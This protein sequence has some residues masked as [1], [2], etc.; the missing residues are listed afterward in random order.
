[1]KVKP[2]L[3]TGILV[4]LGYLAVVFTVWLGTGVDYDTIGDSVDNVR[5]AVT[6]AM[7]CGALY[8]LVVVSILGWWTPSLREPK[9]AHHGWMLAIPVLL[10]IG[11]VLNLAATEWGRFDELG[12]PLGT[13]VAWLAL[14]CVGVGFNEEMITR[15]QLIVGGR[16]SLHEGGV[17]FVSSLCF[18]LLH[19]PNAFFGQSAA[20]TVQQVVFAFAIG[21]A[22]YVTRRVTGLLLVPML[23]HGAWDFST[24][25]QGHSTDGMADKT[26]SFGS[27][28][29]Y[30]AVPLALVAVWRLVKDDGD[31]VEPGADQLAPF[32]QPAAA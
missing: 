21:T 2:S 19:V 29:M 23:L 32:A 16:G 15:G 24:F 3:L 4:V 31:V 25:I 8:I 5:D 6:I 28:A 12:T 20:S 10:L 27:F 14:G 26:V 13:Y 18:G 1:M 17:W 11:I 22:Y 30:V 9:R 7:A